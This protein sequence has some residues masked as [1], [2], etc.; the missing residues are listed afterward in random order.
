MSSL[1]VA[2]TAAAVAAAQFASAGQK[3]LSRAGS[4]FDHGFDAYANGTMRHWKVPGLAIAVI[5]GDDV[6]AKV[7]RRLVKTNLI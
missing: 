5:D 3:P 6:Y 1:R 4:P 7:C 2:V